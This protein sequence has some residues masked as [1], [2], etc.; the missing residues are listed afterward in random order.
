MLPF[1]M[2]ELGLMINHGVLSLALQFNVPPP[3]LL[4]LR[5]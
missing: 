2:P 4:M 3:V 5:V 1:P